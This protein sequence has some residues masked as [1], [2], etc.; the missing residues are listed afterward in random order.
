M[1]AARAAAA[2]G[3][4][5]VAV[6]GDGLVRDVAEG[7]SAA[8]RVMGIVPAG[9]GND[10]ARSLAFPSDVPGLADLLLAGRDAPFD[11]ITLGDTVVIGNVYC[12]I[13]SV[14]NAI[15]NNNRRLPAKLVYRLAPVRAILTWRAPRFT[16]TIDG[17]TTTVDA[18]MVVIGTPA[19]TATG[20]TSFRPPAWTTG[21]WTSCRAQRSKRA[22]A[23]FMRDAQRGTHITRPEV[24]VQQAR[25]VTIAADREVPVCGDGEELTSCRPL[26]GSGRRPCDSSDRDRYGEPMSARAKSRK[27]SPRRRSGSSWKR[28]ERS[29][30]SGS[31]SMSDRRTSRRARRHRNCCRR[32]TPSNARLCSSRRAL[33]PRQGAS[34]RERL[35]PKKGLIPSRCSRASRIRL[36]RH[37]DP[38]RAA[39][40]ASARSS[41]ACREELAC[42]WMSVA[43]IIARRRVSG[44]AVRRRAQRVLERSAR[45]NGSALSRC[46]NPTPAPTWPVCG[47]RR[48]RR[49]Q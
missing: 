3:R 17:T 44:R 34:D 1:D 20:S 12:G 8:D 31:R 21:C 48:A 11:V 18:H 2:E 49:R 16:L 35:D 19:R 30:R 38:S 42:A 36:L 37:H 46:P 23:S 26:H 7:V 27:H 45:G 13:D 9:R 4:V 22:I 41:T 33:S 24:S 32:G 40:W 29:E 6:G 14:S 39:D 25:E 5:V 15:I 28:A 10:L 47:A 43:S